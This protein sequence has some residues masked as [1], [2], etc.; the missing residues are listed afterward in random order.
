[1]AQS[2]PRPNDP[3]G[4]NKNRFAIAHAINSLHQ[5]HFSKET[6]SPSQAN[7]QAAERLYYCYQQTN[8]AR[9]LTPTTF[10]QRLMRAG[11]SVGDYKVLLNIPDRVPNT[12][13]LN[14]YFEE[15][16]AMGRAEHALAHIAHHMEDFA[17]PQAPPTPEETKASQAGM[18]KNQRNYQYRKQ[19]IHLAPGIQPFIDLFRT[20]LLTEL[21]I[22]AHRWKDGR[23]QCPECGSQLTSLFQYTYDQETYDPNLL[24]GKQTGPTIGW[25]CPA[26]DQPFSVTTGT[27]MEE[28][29]LPPA[30]W[31]YMAF[32]MLHDRSA[33]YEFDLPHAAGSCNGIIVTQQEAETM[34]DKIRSVLPF[35]RP[36]VRSN[37]AHIDALKML[38]AAG[39]VPAKKAPESA[40][41]NPDGHET[42]AILQIA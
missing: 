3:N 11:D 39:V 18:T 15:Q 5:E 32:W 23:A 19:R 31:L 8:A 42:Q 41:P 26:C 33:N 34:R 29:N 27:L 28:P 17:P 21:F 35:A 20:P 12:A 40:T 13:D 30:D 22:A 38:A 6:C 1:M 7:Q 37:I 25:D 36:N 9:S 10:R 14:Q 4:H 16:D 24:S 2:G